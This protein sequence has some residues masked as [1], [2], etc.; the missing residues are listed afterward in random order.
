[1]TDRLSAE[2]IERFLTHWEYPA[3]NHDD[4]LRAMAAMALASLRQGEPVKHMDED[5]ETI[6]H[7]DWLAAGD[8]TKEWYSTPLFAAPPVAEGVALAEKVLRAFAED[9]PRMAHDYAAV[10]REHHVYLFR[11]SPPIPRRQV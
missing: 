9:D 1:M 7:K 8:R 11:Y 5:G 6:S 3:G 4:F 2:E 10:A